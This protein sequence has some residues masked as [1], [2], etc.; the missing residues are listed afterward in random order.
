ML[1]R[2]LHVRSP[3]HGRVDVLRRVPWVRTMATDE[4]SYVPDSID[5]STETVPLDDQLEALGYR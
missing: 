1:R 3:P 5:R 2:T 4:G